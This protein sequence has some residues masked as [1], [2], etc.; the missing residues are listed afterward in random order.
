MRHGGLKSFPLEAYSRCCFIVNTV[1]A[2]DICLNN[3]GDRE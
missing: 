1:S 2:E 3:L